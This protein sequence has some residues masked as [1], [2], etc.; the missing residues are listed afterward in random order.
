MAKITR[1][2]PFQ[3][4]K[5]KVIHH[6]KTSRTEIRPETRAFI[7]GAIIAS[8]DGYASANAL[9]KKRSRSQSNLSELVRRVESRAL[10][11]GFNLW[12][13]ILYE[14]DLGRGRS[15]LLT[16]EQKDA[17]IAITTS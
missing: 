4:K 7:V 15:A 16:Q 17:I 9:S 11:S 6:P 8:R 2:K 14:N 13:P 10:E 1:R 3:Y 5:D 12:D